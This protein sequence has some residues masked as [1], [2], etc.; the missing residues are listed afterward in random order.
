[1]LYKHMQDDKKK[2]QPE[3]EQPE[4]VRRDAFGNEIESDVPAV[5]PEAEAETTEDESPTPEPEA[6]TED[7]EQ[8][9]PPD[10]V[11]DIVPDPDEQPAQSTD[12]EETPFDDEK[13]DE[14]IDE[15]VAKEG[16]EVLA[17]QDAAAFQVGAKAA[18]KHGFFRNKWV[19]RI[20]VLLVLGGAA[21]ALAVPVSR[22]WI[23]NTAGVRSSSSVTVVDSTT[24]LPLKG[25]TVAL[26]GQRTDTNSD[27]VAKFSK[28][29]LG[30][31]TLGVKRVGFEEVGRSVVV[32]WGSNPFGSVALKATGVQY[33]IEVKDYLT[34]KPVEGV[35]A[36][37]GEATAVSGKDGKITLTLESPIT[38]QDGITL[39]KVGYRNEK[40]TLNEDPKKP[41]Q[42]T[43]VLARKAVF[44]TKQS[45]KYDVYKSDI[46]GKNRELLLPGTGSENSNITLAVSPDGTRAALVS[47]RDN[48]RDSS[49]FLLSSIALINTE[50]GEKVTIGEA[51]QIQLIDWIG[52]RLV[53]QLGSSDSTAGNRYTVVSYSYTDNTRLQLAAANKLT[54]VTTAQGVVYYAVGADDANPSLQL[55]LFKIKP[56]GSG[57]QRVFDGEL[58][59]V[60]RSTYGTFSLQ[61]SD[62]TWYTYDIAAG[63]KSQISAPSS[64]A[65]RQYLDNAERSK[66]LWISSGALMSYDIPASKDTTLKSQSGLTYPVE[67]LSS[68]A[69]LY[70]VS[71]GGETADYAISLSGGTA[72][73]IS[74]VAA[75]YGFAQSQ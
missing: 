32:G 5:E 20:L 33:V 49:G 63:S 21:A 43:M 42:A 9:T 61:A 57:K 56:D 36:T 30:P 7:K 54:A 73:K 39:S 24:Q 12:E 31:T 15:I 28:L 8:E 51:S 48:K 58:E 50:S 44:V 19:R 71:S 59:T 34:E 66:S 1:M 46:D 45:G 52:T 26:A 40:V 10:L 74:D 6:E 64:L 2:N 16:D 47:T 70:R 37:D 41:T 23:L 18:K 4:E 29:K 13:T 25:V 22:Y 27:G 67:W 69:V 14:A 11:P 60:L 65:N 72:H 62:D 55:G 38:E 17:V 53:F 75:S 68:T 3:N 35:E